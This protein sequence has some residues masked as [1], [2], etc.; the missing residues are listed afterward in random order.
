LPTSDF[1]PL[2]PVCNRT[3]GETVPENDSGFP[4]GSASFTRHAFSAVR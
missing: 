3:F 2:P 1:V 4:Y